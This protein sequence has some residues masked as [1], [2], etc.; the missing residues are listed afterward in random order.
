[1]NVRL[2]ISVAICNLSNGSM[3]AANAGNGIITL[4]ATGIHR[5]DIVDFGYGLPADLLKILV[6]RILVTRRLGFQI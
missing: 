4:Q 2:L 6:R 5:P 3:A 1:M